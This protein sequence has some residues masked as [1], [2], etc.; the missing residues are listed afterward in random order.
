MAQSD[1]SDTSGT[2]CGGNTKTPQKR[3][4]RHRAYC[5]T[6]NNYTVEE[7]TQ[8][9]SNFDTCSEYIYGFEIGEEKTPHIQGYVK[10][11]NPRSFD[12]IKSIIPRAH[13]EKARGNI[14]ANFD[15]CSKGGDYESNID[16][17]SFQEKVAAACLEK[18]KDVKWKKWQQKIIDILDNEPDARKIYWFWENTGNVGKSYL[19]KFICLKYDVIICDGKKENVFNQVKTSM[20]NEKIPKIILLDI[21]RKNLEYINY[22]AIEQLKNGMIYS[23]KYEGSQCLF[24]EPHVIILAN[25]KPDINTMSKDRWAIEKIKN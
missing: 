20:D 13:I 16:L 21:P 25:K 24:P 6:L 4:K 17:R 14:K 7:L 3:C 10:F 22:G 8:I 15:Y 12:R 19:A 11:K 23:G 1:T 2:S 9:H 18:Y 5:F